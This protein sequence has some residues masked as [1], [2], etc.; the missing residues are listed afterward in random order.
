MNA[1]AFAVGNHIAFGSGEHKQGTLVGDALMAHELAHVIQQKEEPQNIVRHKNNLPD[2]RFESD[3][4]TSTYDFLM[5]QTLQNGQRKSIRPKM[6]SGLSIRSCSKGGA[7]CSVT[8]TQTISTQTPESLIIQAPT[9]PVF[10]GSE[11]HATSSEALSSGRSFFV[12][13]RIFN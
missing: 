3:A 11:Q 13:C 8:E 7:P 4:D 1:R 5:N 9:C 2:A 10:R 12:V 6:K